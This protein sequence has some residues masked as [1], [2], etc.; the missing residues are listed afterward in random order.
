MSASGSSPAAASTRLA[1]T[2]V[3]LP[4]EPV[5]TVFPARSATL[6]IPLSSVVTTWVKLL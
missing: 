3:P 2:S 6:L 1:M 5:E 4:A